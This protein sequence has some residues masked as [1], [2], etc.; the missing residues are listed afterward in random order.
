V[1]DP[2]LVESVYVPLADLDLL[3]PHV[4]ARLAAQGLASPERFL[5][6]T[7][8]PEARARWAAR[9]GIT[10]AELESARSR[11]A[12]VS[13]R[14]LGLDRAR[15]LEALGVRT[16]DDLVRWPPEA[17]AAELAAQRPADPRQAFLARRARVWTS[18]LPVRETGGR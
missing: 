1:A 5:R 10:L 16:L 6:A 17:L 15:Q 3:P 18:G 13:R 2:V 12:V 14:G 4:R 11:A 8:G 7:R 9:A